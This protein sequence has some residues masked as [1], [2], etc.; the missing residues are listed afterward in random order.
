MRRAAFENP[1]SVI[2][3]RAAAVHQSKYSPNESAFHYRRK[4]WSKEQVPYRFNVKV[5]KVQVMQV[6]DGFSYL[7][8]LDIFQE[9]HCMHTKSLSP[10]QDE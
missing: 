9:V 10:D 4:R 2:R 8:Q 1:E 5:N 3:A 7:T 6:F